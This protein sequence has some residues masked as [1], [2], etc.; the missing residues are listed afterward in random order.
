MHKTMRLHDAGCT[1]APALCQP[2]MSD[3]DFHRFATFFTKRLGFAFPPTKRSLLAGRLD[4]RLRE[5]GLN[6]YTEYWRVLTAPGGESEVQAAIDRITTNATSF[7]REPAHFAFLRRALLE[8]Q[9]LPGQ[10][11]RLWSAACSTGEEAYSLAM[12][13]AETVG[14][15]TP[16][17]ILA[18][19]ISQRA[20]QRARCGL[21]PLA[22]LR[23][24]P[25][26]LLSRYCL[27]GMDEYRGQMLIDRALRQRVR[28]L[29]LNLVQA[30]PA[31]LGHFAVIF[32]RNVL[33]YFEAAVKEQVLSRIRDRLLPGG[34]LLVGSAESLTDFGPSLEKLQPSIYRRCPGNAW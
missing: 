14:L 7:F 34:L 5:L 11:L 28:F 26:H 33:I 27:R 13:L 10:T 19:D 31:G 4:R 3:T 25:P 17:D 15:E 21:Y 23:R 6:S 32:L 22:G 20:L 1:A 24:L 18:S 30:L 29:P 16:W 12:L 8:R 2:E 9:S